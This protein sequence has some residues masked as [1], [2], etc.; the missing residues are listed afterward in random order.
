MPKTLAAA[1]V[2]RLLHPA[3]VRGPMA[4]NSY[5]LAQHA[6]ENGIL[7]GWSRVVSA[8]TPTAHCE[9]IVLGSFRIM[10]EWNGPR[11]D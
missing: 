8:W 2:D 4:P 11:M 9:W 7:H 5:R 3:Q 10:S 1:T 6:A